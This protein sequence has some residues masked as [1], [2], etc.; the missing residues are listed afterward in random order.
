MQNLELLSATLADEFAFFFHQGAEDVAL[1]FVVVAAGG[2]VGVGA[3]GVAKV[4]A[5][6]VGEEGGIYDGKVVRRDGGRVVAVFFVK[7]FF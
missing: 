3:H 4:D 1:A 5:E 6:G 2:F 7:S